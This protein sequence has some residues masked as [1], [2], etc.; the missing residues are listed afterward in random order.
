MKGAHINVLL[1]LDHPRGMVIA[2]VPAAT[3]VGRDADAHLLTTQQKGRRD[4]AG[5]KVSRFWSQLSVSSAQW[6]P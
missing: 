6:I 3:G 2:A 4:G 1:R 5:L